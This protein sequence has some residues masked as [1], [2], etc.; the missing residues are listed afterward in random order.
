M[1]HFATPDFWY[2]YR[3]LPDE[4]RELAD[5]SFAGRVAR[6]E[7]LRRAWSVSRCTQATP[8]EDSPDPRLNDLRRHD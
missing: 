8:I 7:A 2:R 6:P 1:N 4:V 5:K 3:H